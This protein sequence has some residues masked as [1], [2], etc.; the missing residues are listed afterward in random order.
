MKLFINSY[1]AGSASVKALAEG[2]REAGVD[3]KIIKK[4]N[5]KYKHDEENHV[6]INWGDSKCPDYASLINP[7]TSVVKAANKVET[8]KTLTDYGI[9]AVPSFFSKE[10]AAK[11]LERDKGR[12]VYCR[13]LVNASQGDGIVIAKSVDELVDAPLYTGGIVAAKRKEFRVHVFDGKIIKVQQKKRRN[14]YKEDENYNDLIRN[15]KGGWVF[16][17]EDVRIGRKAGDTCRLAVRALGLTFGAVDILETT[18]GEGWVLEVNTACGLQGS[19]VDAYVEAIKDKFKPVPVPEPAPWGNF[20]FE[21]E[22]DE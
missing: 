15:L 5:S 17:T 6:V 3:T 7:A 8:F 11:F 2:L 14:G 4:T 20:F 9:Q 22:A 13:K 19:T 10:D 16:C 12:V 1:K 18:N 21:D